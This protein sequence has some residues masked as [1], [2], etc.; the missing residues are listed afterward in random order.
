MNSFH[1][2]FEHFSDV[3]IEPPNIKLEHECNE[4]YPRWHSIGIKH[5]NL[6][7]GDS[8]IAQ[9]ATHYWLYSDHLHSPKSPVLCK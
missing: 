7:G 8:Y 5:A 9:G 4:F 3:N 1:I 6:H 2:V